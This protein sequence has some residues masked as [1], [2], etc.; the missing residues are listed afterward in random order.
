M[1]NSTNNKKQIYYKILKS[2]KKLLRFLKSNK[3]FKIKYK[4]LY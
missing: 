1:S 4:K 2:Y 3:K